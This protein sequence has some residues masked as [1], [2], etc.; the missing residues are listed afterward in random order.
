MMLS[1]GWGTRSTAD[2]P[3]VSSRAAPPS[4]FPLAE[5]ARGGLEQQLLLGP[6]V[7]DDGPLKRSNPS[8]PSEQPPPHLGVLR[9][10]LYTTLPFFPVLFSVW[11]S[12]IQKLTLTALLLLAWHAQRICL[13]CSVRD[14]ES[15]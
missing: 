15:T 4:A 13:G 8:V 2:A 12:C 3:F 10:V 9:G 11:P 5:A 14:N 1:A 7:H 6:G